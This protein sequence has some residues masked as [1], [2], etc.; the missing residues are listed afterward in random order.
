MTKVIANSFCTFNKNFLLITASLKLEQ[1]LPA[2]KGLQILKLRSN[3]MK[4]VG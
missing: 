4:L 1:E 3:A 2:M